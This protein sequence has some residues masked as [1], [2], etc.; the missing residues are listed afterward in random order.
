MEIAKSRQL[1]CEATSIWL[2][3]RIRLLSKMNWLTVL[4]PSLLALIAGSAFFAGDDWTPFVAI[5]ALVAAVLSAIHKGLDCDNH[6]KDCRRLLCE[7]RALAV[8]YRKIAEIEPN[9]AEQELAALEDLLRGLKRT[10]SI[11]KSQ[12]NM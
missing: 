5:A 11:T 1:E 3:R 6:Q 2:E 10:D 7:Y 4:V 12:P 9:E 8:G